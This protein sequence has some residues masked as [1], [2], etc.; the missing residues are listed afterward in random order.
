MK[1][2]RDNYMLFFLDYYE[3]VLSEGEQDELMRFLDDHADLKVEFFDFEMVQLPADKSL[4]FPEKHSLKK[5]DAAASDDGQQPGH[6]KLHKPG[7]VSAVGDDAAP[8]I[9]AGNVTPENYEMLFAA[10]AEGDLDAAAKKAVEAFAASDAFYAR[11]LKLLLAARIQPD[12]RIQYDGKPALKRHFVG[13]MRRRI[14]Y[15][16]SAAA[17][18]LLLAVLVYTFFTVTDSQRYAYDIPVAGDKDVPVAVVAPPVPGQEMP[19][20]AEELES[21]V[22]ELPS[23][24]GPIRGEPEAHRRLIAEVDPVEHQIQR[25]TSSFTEAHFS[26]DLTAF[27]RPTRAQQPLA[28]LA[29][30]PRAAEQVPARTETI[31]ASIASRNEFMWLAY[32]DPADLPNIREDEDPDAPSTPTRREIGL[33]ELAINRI[34]EYSNLNLESVEQV[35]SG[36][37][38]SLVSMAG[39][40]VARVAPATERIL[41]IETTRNDEGKLVGFAIGDLFSVSRR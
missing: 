10:Y 28:S 9:S 22:G 29:M 3:G 40:G 16:G 2:T 12:Q 13:V 39:E 26:L 32:V 38:S 36:D 4:R 24:P 35:I 23:D 14:M 1:I 34:S 7:T 11:E 25:P 20:V 21:I 33:A 37:R 6:L 15:Y 18:V 31:P 41:G 8:D 19:A 5:P 27:R 30:E 17:A